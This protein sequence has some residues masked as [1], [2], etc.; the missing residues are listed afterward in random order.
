M[1]GR[2]KYQSFPLPDREWEVKVVCIVHCFVRIS[3]VLE[4]KEKRNGEQLYALFCA[5]LSVFGVDS[6]IVCLCDVQ[7]FWFVCFSVFYEFVCVCMYA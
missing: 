3:V 2:P 6:F 1:S 4:R 5:Y 7:L